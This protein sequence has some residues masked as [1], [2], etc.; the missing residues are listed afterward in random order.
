MHYRLVTPKD[1]ATA[2]ILQETLKHLKTK[3]EMRRDVSRLRSAFCTPEKFDL[4]QAAP[5]R[6]AVTIS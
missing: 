2:S 5:P 4:F 6:A 3:A 1:R